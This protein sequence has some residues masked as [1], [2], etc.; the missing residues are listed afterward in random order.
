MSRTL[1][2]PQPLRPITSHFY[3]A[4]HPLVLDV[5]C[6]SAL[7]SLLNRMLGVLACSRH[8]NVYVPGV[9]ACLA[10]LR[11]Y[12][13]GVLACLKCLRVW[14]VCGLT[15]LAYLACLRAYVLV[16][17]VLSIDVIIFLC[18]YFFCLHLQKSR[19]CN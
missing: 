10:R 5:L 17:G 2:N 12:L 14:C 6:V 19:I 13:L 7:M 8:L 16:L 9:L 18:N 15:C 11:G 4:P 3:L 1:A